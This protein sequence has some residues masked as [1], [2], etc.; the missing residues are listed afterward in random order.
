VLLERRSTIFL[1]IFGRPS[2]GKS[3]ALAGMMRQLKRLLPQR[4][5]LGF[6]EPHPPSNRLVQGYENALFNHPDPDALVDIPKTGA[7]EYGGRL[8]YQDVRFGDEIRRYPRPMFFQV[9]PLPH[10]PNGLNASRY[11]RTLCLYDNAGE[12]FE[13]DRQDKP[14]NPVTQHLAKSS[15]LFFVFDPTQEPLFLRACRGRSADPQIEENMK[16]QT[17]AAIRDPQDTILSTANQNVKKLLGRPITEPLDTPLV[18]IVAKHDAW[19]H[20]LGTDLPEFFI[21][22]REH[23]NAVGGLRVSAVEE[24]SNRIKALLLQ[25]SPA[26]VAA[27]E[28]FSRHIFFVPVSAT[29]CAPVVVERD[30]TGKP[31]YRFRAGSISP[32]W[33]ELPLLWMLARHV[34]GLVPV[35][36]SSATPL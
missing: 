32:Y 15:G 34:P 19:G 21:K 36:K 29:G 22:S 25:H 24:I 26:L 27:A 31:A 16:V 7:S 6:T 18:V 33:I 10:H 13:A 2:A 5:G 28:R 1:S 35:E 20:M 23:G 11:A 17:N 30:A 3:Y 12:D 9:A 14:N 4:F 8:W